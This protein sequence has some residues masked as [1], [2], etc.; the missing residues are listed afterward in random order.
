MAVFGQKKS[1]SEMRARTTRLQRLKEEERMVVEHGTNY[2]YEPILRKMVR[3]FIQYRQML[4][5]SWKKIV[6]IENYGHNKAR[7]SDSELPLIEN[8]V[9]ACNESCLLVFQSVPVWQ[10]A[11]VWKFFIH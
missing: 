9:Q 8:H 11:P 3:F 2:A 7:C 10:I 1:D 6:S 5:I 4:F